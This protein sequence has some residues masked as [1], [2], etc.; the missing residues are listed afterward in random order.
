[1]AVLAVV[2][3]ITKYEEMTLGYHYRA[4]LI[5]E[6]IDGV[7]NP[8]LINTLAIDEELLVAYLDLVT[9]QAGDPFYV[10]TLNEPFPE[11]IIF[12]KRRLSHY[13]QLFREG[14]PQ[15]IFARI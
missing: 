6:I 2:M 1:M 10:V 8:R 4:V 13:E 7:G 11:T 15:L 9:R 14:F 12:H 5:S 3:I